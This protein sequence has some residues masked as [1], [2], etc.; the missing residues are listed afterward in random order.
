MGNN[1]DYYFI[2]YFVYKGEK[3]YEEKYYEENGNF[4]N[5]DYDN[6]YWL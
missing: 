3:D 2:L 1:E 5:D 4:I 6:D